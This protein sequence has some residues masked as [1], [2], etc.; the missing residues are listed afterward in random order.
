[1]QGIC[2]LGAPRTHGG[3][4]LLSILVSRRQQTVQNSTA[5]VL[6]GC[7]CHLAHLHLARLLGVLIFIR[8]YDWIPCPPPPTLT[9]A[10][11]SC[12]SLQYLSDTTLFLHCLCCSASRKGFHLGVLTVD[13]CF[14]NCACWGHQSH[15]AT[16]GAG[17]RF[18]C[19]S[20]NGPE[21]DGVRYC[22]RVQGGGFVSAELL[23][24][25]DA[26]ISS[27]ICSTDSVCR[28]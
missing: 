28:I 7:R 6:A 8:R 20:P 15:V 1:M 26:P 18:I 12:P 25:M 3:S 9:I 16:V 21:I 10:R 24:V 5:V 19:S 17:Y 11:I 22:T 27:S 4:V 13:Y 23:A 2:K 14:E